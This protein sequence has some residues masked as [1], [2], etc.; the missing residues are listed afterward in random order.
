MTSSDSCCGARS[1]VSMKG[2]EG[3]G[4]PDDVRMP[5]K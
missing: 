5:G 2:H 1:Q 3:D 4:E